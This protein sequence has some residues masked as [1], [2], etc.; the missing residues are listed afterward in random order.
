MRRFERNRNGRGISRRHR[1]PSIENPFRGSA[2]HT[3]HV[4][5]VFS[6]KVDVSAKR[7]H[8]AADR[9]GGSESLNPLAFGALERRSGVRGPCAFEMT[10]QTRL[11]PDGS[12][13]IL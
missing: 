9:S 12:A 3:L 8:G 5:I 10:E 6:D 13:Q 11:V 7:N 2:G 4:R 1:A